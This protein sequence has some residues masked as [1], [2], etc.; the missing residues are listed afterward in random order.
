V[1]IKR[2]L[3]GQYHA[4]LRMLRETIEKCPEDLWLAGEHPRN[5]WRIAY[6]VIFYTHL[7]LH[8]TEHDFTPWAKHRPSAR[9]LWDDQDGNPPAIEESFAKAELLE[10]LD[11]VIAGVDGWV[12]SMDLDSDSAGF[13]W[14]SMPK[15]DH[16]FVNLR[17]LSVHVGQLSELVMG[18]G[19]EL[20]WVSIGFAD[21]SFD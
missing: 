3:K 15:L 20:E 7:Y 2:A 9:I 19:E 8:Q 4:G 16:Q 5:T 13:S 11:Q 12:D 21:G 6:H 14:Y 1:E 10:Y 17:H 18:R